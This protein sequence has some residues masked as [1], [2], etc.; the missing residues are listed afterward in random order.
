MTDKT[1]DTYRRKRDGAQMFLAQVQVQRGS[2]RKKLLPQETD[3]NCIP[4]IP[5]LSWK[6]MKSRNFYNKRNFYWCTGDLTCGILDIVSTEL[7]FNSVLSTL[8]SRPVTQIFIPCSVPLHYFVLFYPITITVYPFW[9]IASFLTHVPQNL[10]SSIPKSP[11]KD[12]LLY[13]HKMCCMS[14]WQSSQVTQCLKI[15]I[16]DWI[17]A[18]GIMWYLR[19]CSIYTVPYD[20]SFINFLIQ[21][22]N[23]KIL[24]PSVHCP[25][26][27]T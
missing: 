16:I 9:R 5:Q 18:L 19:N 13:H 26:I 7:Q 15:D 2:V 6:K 10:Y 24:L 20:N 25:I 1:T 21:I 3:F 12:R 4:E 23:L 14:F 11:C 27:P 22:A 17:Q 8:D